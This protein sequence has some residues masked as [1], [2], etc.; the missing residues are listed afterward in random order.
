[1]K[2]FIIVLGILV[3]LTGCASMESIK[4]L[5]SQAGQGVFQVVEQNSQ[6]TPV[7]FGDLEI[8]LEV[9]TRNHGTVLI[10]TTNYGTERYQLLVGVADQTLR[11]QGHMTAETGEYRSSSDPEAGNG[12]RYRFAAS[13]RLPVGTHR[14]TM[15]LP[16]DGVV[17]EQ[18][19]KIRQGNNRLE[20]RPVYQRKN[21]HRLIGFR[22][23]STYYEGI[24]ALVVAS[25]GLLQ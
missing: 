12:V 23:E 15:A 1:M 25:S 21:S 22:G 13:I 9:K 2:N 10:D 8:T 3:L 17:L 5:E 4:R 14:V 24:K 19:V 11:V 7:G 18:E 16:G 20:L 6:S